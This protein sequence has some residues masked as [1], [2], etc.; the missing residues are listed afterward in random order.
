[1]IIASKHIGGK[2]AVALLKDRGGISV[3]ADN[4][5]IMEVR[6]S[7]YMSKREAMQQYKD[8]RSVSDIYLALK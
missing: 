6:N 4:A 3:V 8:I 5:S 7:K 2:W 1:M